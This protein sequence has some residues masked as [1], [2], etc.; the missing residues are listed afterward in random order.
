MLLLFLFALVYAIPTDIGSPLS[1]QPPPSRKAIE[2]KVLIPGVMESNEWCRWLFSKYIFITN[3]DPDNVIS[4]DAEPISTDP[5]NQVVRIKCGDGRLYVPATEVEES[6][7]YWYFRCPPGTSIYLEETVFRMRDSFSA[8][9]RTDV[10]MREPWMPGYVV[11]IQHE[12]YDMASTSS[13]VK[14][15]PGRTFCVDAEGSKLTRSK[16]TKLK[17]GLGKV[18]KSMKMWVSIPPRPPKHP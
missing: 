12:S 3:A 10:R 2:I 4:G 11:N 15:T 1:P 16:T 13:G 6:V 14:M 7:G 8:Q 9:C 18:V 17:S 5:N